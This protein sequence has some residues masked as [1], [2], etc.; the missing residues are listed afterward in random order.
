[1]TLEQISYD[2]QRSVANVTGGLFGGATKIAG[3]A[4]RT[5]YDIARRLPGADAAERG[6]QQIERAALTELR[7]RIDEVTD[8]YMSALNRPRGLPAAQGGAKAAAG[9][10]TLVS[11]KDGEVEP[12]R[13][14][15]ADLLERSLEFSEPRASEYLY[16]SVLRELTPDEARI[17]SALSDGSPFPLV[18]VAE[19]VGVSG[20]GRYVLRNASS[21]GKAAGVTLPNQTPAYLTRLFALGL[22]ET[23]EESP[24]LATQYDILLTDEAVRQA[25]ASVKRA[26]FI[27]RT[28]H[29]SRFGADFWNACDPARGR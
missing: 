24:E 15:M 2:D 17:I 13:A 19:R 28:V 1:M 25:G 10:G 9:A 18:D 12:L 5:G 11:T 29:I 7:K 8:P 16:A 22:L 26:K 23:D 20:V 4:A 21:V 27:R 14:A 3:W 6:I